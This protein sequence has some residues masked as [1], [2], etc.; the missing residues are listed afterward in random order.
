M[1]GSSNEQD[2][3]P[4]AHR[5]MMERSKPFPSCWRETPNP[6]EVTQPD[7]SV[8]SSSCSEPPSTPAPA[9]A[10]FFRLLAPS[11]PWTLP[12]ASQGLPLAILDPAGVWLR[13]S[14]QVA[15]K[16]APV[17]SFFLHFPAFLSYG[18]GTI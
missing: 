17:L 3:F 16:V 5:Q 4:R 14:P 10:S 18:N 6:A 13:A 12:E 8:S 9:A 15:V 2:R 1:L 7:T 11:L